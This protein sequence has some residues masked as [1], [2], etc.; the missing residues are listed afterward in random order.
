MAVPTGEPCTHNFLR[1]APGRLKVNQPRGDAVGRHEDML[2]THGA[3]HHAPSV[4]ALHG[5]G[6][7]NRHLQPSGR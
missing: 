4:N 3:M 5:I 2:G 1:V 7:V 6:Q